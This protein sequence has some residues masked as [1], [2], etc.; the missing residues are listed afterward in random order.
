MAIPNIKLEPYQISAQRAAEHDGFILISAQVQ[1]FK[2]ASH[3]LA[4]VLS[5][6]PAGFPE[7]LADV[8]VSHASIDPSFLSSVSLLYT[9]NLPGS[10]TVVS[11]IH[12]PRLDLAEGQAQPYVDATRAA[13]KRAVS[14]G[15][16][17][18]LIAFGGIDQKTQVADFIVVLLSVFQELYESYE[19]RLFKSEK[20]SY[21]PPITDISVMVQGAKTEQQ[22]APYADGLKWALAVEA[23]RVVARDICGGDPE[24]MAPPQCAAYIEQAFAHSSAIGVKTISDPAVM[25][26][27][28]PLLHAVARCSLA[29]PR[30]HPRVVTLEYK[31]KDQS[32]VTDHLF[33]V[34]KGV[35]MDTGGADL[36][37]NG[38]MRG[39]SRDKGGAATAAGF[40]K[41][42]ELLAPE[43]L[44]VTI[45]LGFVRNS[46]GPDSFVNDEIITSRA[47]VR[48]LVVNTDAEGRMVMADL[49]AQ[50]AE[51]ARTKLPL[52][53]PHLFTIATLTG[54]AIRAYGPYTAAVPNHHAVQ[55]GTPGRLS[56]AGDRCGEPVE[57]SRMK[58]DDFDLVR[59]S[60]DYGR[61]QVLQGND[62]PSTATD[63]GHQ[64]PMAF[65][66]IAA[67]VV[68]WDGPL[69]KPLPYTHLDIAGAAEEKAGILSKC[70]GSPLA[71]MTA[72]LVNNPFQNK[73]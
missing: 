21:V 60:P 71:A 73:S 8:F 49:L 19:T 22:A 56:V 7:N 40:A 12:A 36:K 62:K 70:T 24:R 72:A 13:I 15:I 50:A 16:K 44:N 2:T 18:P 3:S 45:H 6:F 65:M 53:Q 69:E 11:P 17:K 28:Y 27:E 43:F 10:R 35:T 64:F 26:K 1:R 48:V 14:A 9:P 52:V 29:V 67:G 20:G 30:H 61:D 4:D 25:E 41:V 57:V 47:G 58:K 33:I 51:S 63:R 31:A 38:A 37:T 39:M 5:V 23:G 68:S 42:I 66:S 59:P 32:K 54:H 46:I 34:G 55:Q